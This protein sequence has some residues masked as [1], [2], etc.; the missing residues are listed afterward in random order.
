M[1][2]TITRETKREGQKMNNL[3]EPKKKRELV[4]FTIG[5]YFTHGFFNVTCTQ[6]VRSNNNGRSKMRITRQRNLPFYRLKYVK[7]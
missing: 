7:K 5:S 1:A 2:K 4:P 3:Q 6:I